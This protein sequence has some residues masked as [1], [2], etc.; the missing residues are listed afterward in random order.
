MILVMAHDERKQGELNDNIEMLDL[1]DTL[2]RKYDMVR[3][4]EYYN[5]N[6][7]VYLGKEIYAFR[8]KD[9]GTGEVIGEIYKF[10]NMG[11]LEEYVIK[12]LGEEE[13]EEVAHLLK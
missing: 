2:R 8:T 3:L 4:E 11:E 1:L 5:D 9:I 12:E 6:L 13:F 7:T 10:E